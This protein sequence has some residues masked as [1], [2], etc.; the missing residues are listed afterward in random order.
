M[1]F[2]DRMRGWLFKAASAVTTVMTGVNLSDV[3]LGRLFGAIPTWSGKAVTVDTALQLDTVWACVRLIAE[4]IATLPLQLYDGAGDT[5]A[6]VARTHPLYR[7]LHDRPNADMTAVDFWTC[8]VGA[9]LLWGNGF[10]QVVRRGDGTVIALNPLRPDRMTVRRDRESGQLVYTYSWQGTVL[11]LE[12]DEIFHVKGFSL[13]GMLGLSP[14][15]VGRQ[16]LATAL[17]ADETAGKTFANGLLSQSYIKS[18]DWLDDTQR[19]RAKV[20]LEDYTSSVNAN[21]T[22]LLEGGWTVE[23]IGMNP[24]VMQL[25]QTRGWSVETICRLF[26]VPPPMIG[27][28]QKSTAWGTGL[29]QMMLWFL[30]FCLRAHL[31]RIEQAISQRLLSV[32]DQQRYYAEHTVEGLLRA[33][34]A[35]RAALQSSEA[36]NGVRTRNEI[37]ASINLPPL[38]GGDDLTVQSNMIPV[39]MLG[40]VAVQPTKKPLPQGGTTPPALPASTDE[41]EDD[42]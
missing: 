41:E 33:D 7:I 14:I 11:T 38:P 16:V 25:L 18:P 24:E 23:S 17:A 9:L 19:A 35:A 27:H 1:N 40:K 32:A 42:A 39:S 3:R 30:Q 21:K 28:M 36:Q 8:I 10:A 2:A 31:V 26:G 5:V 37:R 15:A 34:S 12:E 6:K 4:T 29:E 22:P 13:D 20:I